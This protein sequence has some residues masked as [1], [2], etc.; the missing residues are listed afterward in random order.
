[1]SALVEVRIPTFKRSGSLRRALT[2]LLRQTWR[3]WRAIIFDDSPENEAKKIVS[4]FGDA[5]IQLQSNPIRLGAAGNLDQCFQVRP[6]VGGEFAFV[7]EDDNGLRPEFIAANVQALRASGLSLL[8]REQEIFDELGEGIWSATGLRTKGRIYP[9][10]ERYTPLY[11]QGSIFLNDAVANGGLFWDTAKCRSQLVVGNSVADS[12]LQEF[13]RTVQ[14]VEPLIFCQEPLGI[15]TRMGNT[16][17]VRSFLQ[18][19]VF[20]RS[21]QALQQKLLS[22]HGDRLLRSLFDT[23]RS[24]RVEELLLANLASLGSLR[25]AWRIPERVKSLTL[26][27]KGCARRCLVRNVL[28]KY[29]RSLNETELRASAGV[30]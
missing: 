18:N 22:V 21:L 1:M 9:R 23:A 17:S 29:L 6:L 20:G 24:L 28:K 13:C 11:V 15:W 3:E 10:A 5:R 30:R 7:L 14:I 12:G 26:L 25:H 8:M 16:R 27:G 19:R 2:C 4:T